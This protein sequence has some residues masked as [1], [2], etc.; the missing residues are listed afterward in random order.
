MTNELVTGD[1][2]PG[3]EAR[4]LTKRFGTFTSVDRLDLAVRR[5]EIFCLLGP[6]GSGKS[7]SVRMFTGLLR[8]TSGDAL[9][10]GESIVANPVAAKR[11]LGALPEEA[12]LFPN[13]TLGEHLL[14]CGAAGL[15]PSVV[16][17]VVSGTRIEPLAAIG[18][19]ALAATCYRQSLRR[20]GGRLERERE[21]VRAALAS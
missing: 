11:R 7:T 4:A 3:V 15:A 16:G 13:T 18:A 9:V 12:A 5:G 21:R 17:L 14:L 1:A 10:D 2:A 20:C 8:P 6:N 19:L